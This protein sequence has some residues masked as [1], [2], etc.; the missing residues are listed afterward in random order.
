MLFRSSTI[1]NTE[2]F[3]VYCLKNLTII[4]ILVCVSL[5]EIFPAHV[6]VLLPFYSYSETRLC[7]KTAY[8]LIEDLLTVNDVGMTKLS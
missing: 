2:K 7:H 5:K 4:N 3:G 6:H 1:I 8:I